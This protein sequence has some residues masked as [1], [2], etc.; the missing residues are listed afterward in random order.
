MTTGN[1]DLPLAHGK[2]ALLAC[3]VWEHAYYLDYQND[4]GKFIEIFLTKLVNWPFVHQQLSA[5][6]Q[7]EQSLDHNDEPEDE[8]VARDGK[9]EGEGSYSAAR[10][11]R[12]GLEKTIKSGKIAAK[13]R[14]ARRALESDEGEEL[15]EA[16]RRGQMANTTI[17]HRSPTIKDRK[18]G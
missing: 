7:D 15:R 4:R 6:E 17:E 1:A 18:K 2:T 11:Y 10:S 5:G 3:D 8:P 13:A 16:E 14:E 12:Q 9:V